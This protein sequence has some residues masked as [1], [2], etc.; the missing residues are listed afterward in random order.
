MESYDAIDY[1]KWPNHVIHWIEE[2]EV[3]RTSYQY[4]LWRASLAKL[5]K[6]CKNLYQEELNGNLAKVDKADQDKYKK[7]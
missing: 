2:S 7:Q 3:A 4:W 6:P 5:G 1:D